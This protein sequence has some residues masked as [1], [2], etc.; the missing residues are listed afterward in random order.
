MASELLFLI[1]KKLRYAH[2]VVP[3][4]ALNHDLATELAQFP[5]IEIVRQ[6]ASNPVPDD[7]LRIIRAHRPDCV[8][9]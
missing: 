3:D 5:E 9:I 1:A 4:Q 6:V 2:L 7:F 8:F